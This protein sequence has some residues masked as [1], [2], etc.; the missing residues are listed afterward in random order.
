MTTLIAGFG[1]LYHRRLSIAIKQPVP[2]IGQMLLPILWVLVVAPALARA[3]GGFAQH[4]DYFTFVCIGQIV[5]VLPFS[6][7]FAGL[8]VI[9]DK[10]WGI[11]RELLVAPVRRSTISLANTMVVLT[12]AAGQFSLIILLAVVRGAHF[13]TDPLRA[14]VAVAAA[15]LMAAGVYGI[16]EA[17]AYTLVQPQAFGT[18][19]P[20]IGATPYALCGAIFPIAVLPLGVKQ[21][22]WALPWT[23]CV[24]LLRFGLLGNNASGLKQIWPVQS[25]GIAAFLS[26][27]TLVIFAAI[28]QT[29]AQRAF[30]KSTTR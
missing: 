19:I 15:G 3:F 7:M 22:V 27:A 23:Q 12:V 16:A 10:D 6:A 18:L 5:F 29:F 13:H 20:V 14:F 9:F 1:P 26:L 28:T 24:E 25:T 30:K 21:L 8:V 11:L 2:L 17:L 4:V